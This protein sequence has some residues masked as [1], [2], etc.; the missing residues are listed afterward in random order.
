LERDG[1]GGVAVVED[2]FGENMEEWEKR[3]NSS[4]VEQR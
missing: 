2:A 4:P 1:V 3:E